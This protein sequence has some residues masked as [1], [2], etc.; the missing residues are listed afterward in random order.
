V[1][2]V[3]GGAKPRRVYF[4]SSRSLSEHQIEKIRGRL[5]RVLKNADWSLEILGASH[6][7]DADTQNAEK[8]HSK[9]A[10]ENFYQSEFAGAR[11]FLEQRG[12]ASVEDNAL[13]L[14]LTTMGPEESQAL[15]NR[16]FEEIILEALAAKIDKPVG[17]RNLAGS[18]SEKLR[19]PTLLSDATIEMHARQLKHSGLLTE[20]PAEHWSLTDTG[21]ARIAEGP[22]I[23]A[24]NLLV[25]R[26]AIRQHL[27]GLL[28]TPLGADE[29]AS[30]WTAVESALAVM[31]YRRGQELIGIAEM[32]LSAS[33]K[34][35]VETPV[36]WTQL[37]ESVAQAAASAWSDPSTREDITTA[38][39]DLFTEGTGSAVDWLVRVCA[40]FVAVCSMGMEASSAS[41]L[42]ERLKHIAVVPDTDVVLTLLSEG[43]VEHG[44]TLRA[45]QR[46]REMG[47]PIFL[48]EPVAEEAAHHAWIAEHDFQEM[49]GLLPGTFDDALH[50]CRNA[51]VRGFAQLLRTRTVRSTNAWSKYIGQFIGQR[52]NDSAKL[53]TV[54]VREEGYRPAARVDYR[55]NPNALRLLNGLIK[56][57]DR[58]GVT[59]SRRKIALDKAQR[60]AEMM[61][62][63]ATLRESP[64]TDWTTCVL[65]SSSQRLREWPLV[66]R[67]TET[68]WVI[69][70]GTWVAMLALVPGVTLSLEAMRHFLFDNQSRYR[71][72]ETQQ[73]LL[74]ALKASGSYE[75]GWARRSSL[76]KSMDSVVLRMARSYGISSKDVKKRVLSPETSDENRRISKSVLSSV[77]EEVAAES[78]AERDLVRKVRDLEADNAR[79]Q[80]LLRKKNR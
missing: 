57:L 14:A 12:S 42:K 80:R 76:E 64:S 59:G 33:P 21:K 31:F 29:F 61:A 6:I 5:A 65:V 24:D 38:V 18:I 36:A 73:L 34:K 8:N 70:P 44:A 72:N 56:G 11:R 79:L 28:G 67:D 17:T 78:K 22:A 30:V 15:R 74:R 54:M 69:S 3:A 10:A 37:V 16:M 68:P 2:L 40:A 41:V 77:V 25:G 48:A 52:P 66:I 13:R 63:V 71:P 1:R 51:F 75:L 53:T 23:A 58:K 46:W 26:E 39:R 60:D 47:G 49:R 19:L 4:C 27:A 20:S 50:L 35:I 7:A 45:N 55:G 9:P 62:T 32:L 43:E